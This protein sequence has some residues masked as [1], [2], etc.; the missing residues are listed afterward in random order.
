[1]RFHVLD[2][3]QHVLHAVAQDDA[4]LGPIQQLDREQVFQLAD[5]AADGGVIEVEALGGG[6]DAALAGDLQKHPEI[7]PFDDVSVHPAFPSALR[8]SLRTLRPRP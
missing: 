8:P 6:M 1:M 4:A 2:V 7:I 3:P 5:A